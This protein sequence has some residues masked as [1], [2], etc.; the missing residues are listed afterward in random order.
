MSLDVGTLVGYLKLDTTD[1]GKQVRTGGC[2]N[3]I[4]DDHPCLAA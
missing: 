1:V 2:A 4:F 3:L